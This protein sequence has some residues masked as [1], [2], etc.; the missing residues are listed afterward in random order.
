MDERAEVATAGLVVAG[1]AVL[2]VA[3]HSLLKPISEAVRPRLNR[4]PN[5]YQCN[6]QLVITGLRAREKPMRI[7][8]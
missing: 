5:H 6:R 4:F 1:A 3:S 2:L 7:A 8:R